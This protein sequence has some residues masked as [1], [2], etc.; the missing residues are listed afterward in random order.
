[1]KYVNLYVFGFPC[2][3]LSV[4]GKQD[5]G[6]GKS[7]LV[8]YSLDIID[9]TL[10]EYILF[11]NVK[12]LLNKKFSSFY[13]MI[14]KR[15]EK[16]YNFQLLQ[17][18]SKDFGIPHH[19]ERVFGVGSKKGM[20]NATSNFS[21]TKTPAHFKDFIEKT[22]D[23]KYFITNIRRDA[24]ISTALTKQRNFLLQDDYGEVRGVNKNGLFGDKKIRYSG[25]MFCENLIDKHGFIYPDKKTIRLFTPRECARL[26]GFPD[27]FILPSNDNVSYRQFGNTITVNVLEEIFKQ[28]LI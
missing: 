11:E 16:N 24:I 18:N 17:L 10:P 15:I 21:F 5:L 4:A 13:N 28:F 22:V 14:V 20:H 27:S 6:G 26:Q 8:D 19:R 1:M 23:S 25:N 9:K 3:D 2:Q 12:G 7:V